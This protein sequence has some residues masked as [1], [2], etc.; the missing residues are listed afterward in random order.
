MRKLTK[1]QL[2]NA[3]RV[4]DLASALALNGWTQTQM[5][6]NIGYRADPKANNPCY[7]AYGAIGVAA[8]LL[9]K[10]G[11][12]TRVTALFGVTYSFVVDTFREKYQRPSLIQWND[13]LEPNHESRR[14]V[15]K[16]LR[17]IANVARK[18]ISNR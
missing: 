18:E 7:C 3:A 16:E 14:L 8:R 10:Q 4:C 6:S 15:A 2:S 11:E 13:A 17:R 12:P 5:A 1:H 9:V